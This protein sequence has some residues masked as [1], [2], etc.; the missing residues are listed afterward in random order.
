M[1]NGGETGECSRQKVRLIQLEALKELA[2]KITCDLPEK[3][4]LNAQTAW[5]KRVEKELCLP[6]QALWD[7]C[8]ASGEPQEAIKRDITARKQ[9]ATFFMQSGWLSQL[10]MAVT[11]LDWTSYSANGLQPVLLPLWENMKQYFLDLLTDSDASPIG[12]STV[13]LSNQESNCAVSQVYCARGIL[14][15]TL[16]VDTNRESITRLKIT[17]P[18]HRNLIDDK[19]VKDQL[20]L[21]PHTEQRL[22]RAKIYLSLVNPCYPVTISINPLARTEW[23]GEQHA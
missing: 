7:A 18:T 16:C 13:K 22:S 21:I 12:Q 11:E 3:M 9:L 17:S 5:Y 20:A 15:Y 4:G 14:D 8:F 2:W 1:S 23:Q 19:S 6:Q 10:T